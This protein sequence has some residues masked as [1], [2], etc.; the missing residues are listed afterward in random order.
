[1]PRYAEI[2][3]PGRPPIRQELDAIAAWVGAGKEGVIVRQA[4]LIGARS[5]VDLFPDANGVRVESADGASVALHFHG[6]RVRTAMVQWG[7]EIFLDDVRLTFLQTPGSRRERLLLGLLAVVTALTITSFLCRGAAADGIATPE[8]NPPSF[9]EVVASCTAV[10][11]EAAE[12]RGREAERL[13]LAK[14][15]RYAFDAR[16]GVEALA[17]LQES[18]VC[19]RDVGRI[20]DAQRMS[21]EFGGF[22]ERVGDDYAALRLRLRSAL[23]AQRWREALDATRELER[24]LGQGDD[25]YRQWLASLR[26][27]LEQ[28]TAKHH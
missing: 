12:A 11:P 19:F 14:K 23:A 3:A 22:R 10:G 9:F 7:D 25:A 21:G 28:K 8:L 13:A 15:A 5:E 4:E 6:D 24:F 2:H 18:A 27:Q 17:L 26:R 1:M 20:Q 16:D